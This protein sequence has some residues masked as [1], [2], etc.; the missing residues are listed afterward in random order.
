MRRLRRGDRVPPVTPYRG[1]G[2]PQLIAC[3]V[4]R[5]HETPVGS[6]VIADPAGKAPV[7]EVVRAI[8]KSAATHQP[9][10]LPLDKSDPFYRF[11]GHVTAGKVPPS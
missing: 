5:R 11:E 7:V 10:V 2:I 3:K 1:F 9:V 4:C 6:E 8:Y